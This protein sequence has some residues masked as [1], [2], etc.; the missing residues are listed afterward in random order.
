[1]T[2]T[3]TVF[4]TTIFQTEV[5]SNDLLKETLCDQMLEASKYMKAPEAWFTNKLRT[6]FEEEPPGFNIL[7]DNFPLLKREYLKAIGKIIKR[8]H[9]IDLE[10]G[11]AWYNVYQDGEFQDQHNHVSTLNL[12]QHHYSCVHFLSFNPEYH[13]PP[14]FNDPLSPLPSYTPEIDESPYREVWEPEVKEG[15]LLMFPIY[16][17][18]SVYPCQK[19]DYPRITITFNFSL[20]YYVSEEHG[21]LSDY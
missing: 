14:V 20:T 6:S 18:H 11:D 2:K 21:E 4:P 8:P 9:K 15:D 5:D 17:P 19:S 16:V 10:H 7:E 3:H 12:N 13:E 1:M